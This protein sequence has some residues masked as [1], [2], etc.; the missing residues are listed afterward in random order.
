LDYYSLLLVF[1]FLAGFFAAAFSLLS[2]LFSAFTLSTDDFPYFF[3]ILYR[4][5]VEQEQKD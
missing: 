5:I 2:S 4:E 1:D 3:I